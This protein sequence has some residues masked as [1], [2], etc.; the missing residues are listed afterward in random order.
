MGRSMRL[1]REENDMRVKTVGLLA[2]AMVLTFLCWG[3]PAS[4]GRLPIAG[5]MAKSDPAPP[6][7]LNPVFD[8]V[9]FLVD[10][11]HPKRDD[12]RVKD[13][14]RAL[15]AEAQ[16][17]QHLPQLLVDSRDFRQRALE[18]AQLVRTAQS[19]EI[20]A[21]NLW[22][23]VGVKFAETQRASQTVYQPATVRH[24]LISSI[25][26]Q[27]AED[28]CRNAVRNVNEA[29]A[30]VSDSS[31]STDKRLALLAAGQNLDSLT[32]CAQ[33][34][35]FV[36][37]Q[38]TDAMLQSYRRMVQ[39]LSGSPVSRSEAVSSR[40]GTLPFT[41][42]VAAAESPDQQPYPL[43]D[44]LKK[45]RDDI[46]QPVNP[47]HWTP[48]LLRASREHAKSAIGKALQQP[49]LPQKIKDQIQFEFLNDIT[50]WNEKIDVLL[51]RPTTQAQNQATRKQINR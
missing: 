41:V 4:K 47:P 28:K 46:A 17:L 27:E 38:G 12:P 43:A 24:Q 40:I 19:D 7:W 25:G 34:V 51:L 22:K 36:M 49:E 20:L 29:L 33:Y 32:Y 16:A 6:A 26:L 44:Y 30:R 37:V 21:A 23:E 45:L 3:A 2:S 10:K 5:Q 15:T 31:T 18:L 1:T 14:L 35:E 8:F 39:Q 50:T 11:F 9:R 42:F 13:N 48:A